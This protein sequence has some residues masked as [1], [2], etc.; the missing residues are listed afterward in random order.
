MQKNRKPQKTSSGIGMII[1]RGK[2]VLKAVK[3]D[4]KKDLQEGIF[5]KGLKEL[6]EAN[7]KAIDKNM[8]K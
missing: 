8:S 2:P 5:L 3:E 7:T 1:R 6:T 4:I